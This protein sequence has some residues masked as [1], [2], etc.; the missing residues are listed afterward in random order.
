MVILSRTRYKN[1]AL[2]QQLLQE[3]FLGQYKKR[4]KINSKTLKTEPFF[5]KLTIANC[6]KRTTIMILA[7]LS[8]V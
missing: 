5:S 6:S 8:K 3:F 7:F 2:R 4:Q 1:E